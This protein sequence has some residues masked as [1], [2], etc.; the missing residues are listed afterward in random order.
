MH[1]P[2]RDRLENLL[3]A[4]SLAVRQKDVVSHL[5]SC[6]ECS[7]ELDAM[8][9]QSSILSALRA[10]EAIEPAAGFY[11]RVLQ[12]IED[13]EVTSFWSIFADSPF[14]KRLAF[15]S[16]TVMLTLGGYVASQEMSDRVSRANTLALSGESHYDAPVMGSQA[17][18]RDAVL[19]NFAAHRL[20]TVEGRVQ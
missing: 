2:I 5:A 18:Q 16:L 8:R 4:D 14:T 15:A 9:S 13:R 6:D 11:A 1:G 10:P 7:T 20:V 19:E 12:K 3:G 17:E